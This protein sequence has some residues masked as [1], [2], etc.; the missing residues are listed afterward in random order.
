M[1]R[2]R[3]PKGPALVDGL[4][5]PEDAKERL[6]VVLETIAGERTIQE[7]CE[8]LAIS[9]ARFHQIRQQ[10]LQGAIDCLVPGTPGRPPKTLLERDEKIESLEQQLRDLKFD[11]VASQVRTEIAVA[12]PH[13]LRTPT[14]SPVK[15]KVETKGKKQRKRKRKRR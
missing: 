13:L 1:K 3:P 12:M 14:V 8:I 9:E 15:K 5:G 6:R 7:A 4:D 2:G 11:L 10:A